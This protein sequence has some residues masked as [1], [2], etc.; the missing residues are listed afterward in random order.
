MTGLAHASDGAS[1][2]AEGVSA[3]TS[4]GDMARARIDAIDLARYARTRNALDGHTSGLGPYLTHGVTDVSEVIARLASRGNVAWGDKFVYELGW[5]EYAQH[6]WRVLGEEIWQ[7]PRSAPAAGDGVYARTMPR[8]LE[9]A[10]TGVAIIDE[11]VKAL[12]A[13][14]VLHNHARMWIASYAVHIRKVD[15]RVGATWMYAHLLDGDLAANTLGWQWVAGTWTGKPYLFNAD[16]VEKYAPGFASRGAAIDT[17]YETLD[18][19]ARSAANFAE[20]SRVR[21]SSSNTATV[22]PPTFDSAIVPAIARELGMRVID[23]VPEE[24]RGVFRHPWSLKATGDGSAIGVIVPS[25]HGTF[26]WSERRWRFVLRAMQECCGG[27]SCEVY[28]GDQLERR[29]WTGVSTTFTLHPGYREWV[30]AIAERGGEVAAPPR[31]FPDPAAL[32]RSF[33]AFWAMVTRAP[34]PY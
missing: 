7:E 3:R 15:W 25:F 1:R 32:S 26:P 23:A 21:E 18:A 29:E 28:L 4:A 27:A 9:A 24:F 11:Q 16:N 2:A 22:A 20:P 13:T 5:R 14:G 30:S 8:D 34:F 19:M 6:A 31:A 17:T 10:S 33:S 12:Y